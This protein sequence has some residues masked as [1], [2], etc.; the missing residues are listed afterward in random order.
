MGVWR[1]AADVVNQNGGALRV[2]QRTGKVVAPGMTRMAAKRYG[3]QFKFAEKLGMLFPAIADAGT[4]I[5]AAGAALG[6]GNIPLGVPLAVTAVNSSQ[7]VFQDA[8]DLMESAKEMGAPRIPDPQWR[9]KNVPA[10]K[11]QAG[12]AAINDFDQSSSATKISPDVIA[13]LT[14]TMRAMQ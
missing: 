5:V 9:S 7:R 6:A 8:S 13:R 14:K 2:L 12:P 10:D 3:K 1:V 4:E 11:T